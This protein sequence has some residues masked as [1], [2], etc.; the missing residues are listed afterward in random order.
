MELLP[1]H[2]TLKD[3]KFQSGE[4]LEKVKM[5]YTTLGKAQRDGQGK[6]NNAILFLH[7]WAGDYNSFKRFINLTEPGQVFDREKYFI[8][9]TTALG[10]PGS[11]SPSSSGLGKDFPQYNVADMVNIQ[12]RLINE[13][14]E[15]DHLLGVVGTSMGGFQSLQWGVSYPAFMD[16]LIHIVTGPAV[17]GRNLAIFQLMNNLIET[18]PSYMDGD[19]QENPL[20]AVKNLNQ[21]MFLF[22]FT[23]PYYHKEFPSQEILLQALDEQGAEGLKLDARDVVWRNRA[24][25]SFDIR[26]ELYK[27]R[28]KSLIIGIE[29]DEYFPPEI[30]AIPLS[31]SIENSQLFIYKSELGHLG[32]NQVEKMKDVI[33]DFIS[34]NR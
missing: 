22:A 14:L 11:S 31:E 6:I 21:F 27:T 2:H 7:G 4:V 34:Q 5:E 29:G 28:A 16:F 25:I 18:D 8:I 24:A 23:I 1:Q 15:I 30:E 12:Y 10:S 3:F 17:I 26:W 33:L 19:Y 32:I 20:V 13:H 9:S